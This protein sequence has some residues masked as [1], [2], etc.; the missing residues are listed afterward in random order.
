MK[1]KELDQ[2]IYNNVMDGAGDVLSYSSDRTSAFQVM[3]AMSKKGWLWLIKHY[4]GTPGYDIT[5]A[6][7]EDVYNYKNVAGPFLPLI[8]CLAAKESIEYKLNKDNK[9]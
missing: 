6:H 1:N 8:I 3:D 7:S 9:I 5:F 4:K 2:W